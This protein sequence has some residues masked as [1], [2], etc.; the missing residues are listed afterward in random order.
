[1]EQG[2]HTPRLPLHIYVLCTKSGAQEL[3]EMEGAQYQNLEPWRAS[4]RAI[5]KAYNEAHIWENSRVGQV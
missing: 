3:D 1:M 2:L 5:M 4:C